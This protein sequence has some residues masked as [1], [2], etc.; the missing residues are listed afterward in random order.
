MA[1]KSKK[2]LETAKLVDKKKFYTVEEA[3]ELVTKLGYTKFTSSIDVAIKTFANPKYNDQ[4]IRATT[5]LPH[6]NGK[7]VKVAVYTT[8]DK[9]ADVKKAGADL[10]GSVDLLA[11]IEKG[12]FNFDVLVTSP[13]LMKDLAKVAKALGPKGLM[14]NPKA[15][16]V[17]IDLVGAVSEIKKG[18]FEF[19][20]DKTGNIH[21]TVG[22]AT[23]S[24][25]QL[26]DNI[27]A[28]IS[29]VNSHKPTGV[30][31]KLIKK[32]VVSPT[33]GPGLSLAV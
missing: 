10:A 28:F 27:T 29:A 31:G 22:K 12:E 9:V 21:A 2:Y 11:A 25:T 13:D 33:M 5:S 30:K 4:N 19:K 16:T 14:P 7:T 32:I 23:F 3:A 8:E 26:A 1:K 24:A 15:G 20:L 17:A 6:G 18:R